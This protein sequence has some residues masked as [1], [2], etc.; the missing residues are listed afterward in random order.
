MANNHQGS[1]KHAKLIVDK[2]ADVANKYDINAGIK[3]QF[4]QL[5]TF[6]HKDYIDSDLKYVKRFKSTRLTKEQFTEITEYIR[7]KN[8]VTIATPFDNESLPWLEDL[9]ISELLN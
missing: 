3:L 4:R 5:D 8:L 9:D 2:F 6:I 7:S 1:V